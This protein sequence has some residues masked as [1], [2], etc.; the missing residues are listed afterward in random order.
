MYSMGFANLGYSP[1]KRVYRP[2]A[3]GNTSR[4]G[5]TM[6]TSSAGNTR[7]DYTR[8]G[9]RKLTG[10]MKDGVNSASRYYLRFRDAYRQAAIDLTLGQPVP[11][12]IFV[13][14]SEVDEI[15]GSEISEKEENLKMIIEDCKK[16]LIVEPELCLG[17]WAL[18]NADPVEGDSDQQDMDIILLLSQRSVYV[19]WYDD[20]IEQ[21]TRYQRIYLEDIDKIEIGMEPAVFKSKHPCLRLTYH[22][23]DGEGLI[24]MFRLPANRFFNNKSTA[25]QTNEDARDSLKV[26]AET[27]KSAQLIMSMEL[28]V[29][30]KLKL[31]KKK[32]TTH[33]DIVD[34][35]KQQH[36]NSLA[37]IS[38][39]RDISADM[40]SSITEDTGMTTLHPETT[41]GKPEATTARSK[42]PLDFLNS[43]PKPNLTSA[44]ARFSFPKPNL[45]VNLQNLN[46]MKRIKRIR[47]G[48]DKDDEDEVDIMEETSKD[49]VLD[50]CGILASSPNQIILSSMH[51]KAENKRNSAHLEH[52]HSRHE[53]GL[54]SEDAAPQRR[55]FN[56]DDMESN[57]FVRLD[58][59]NNTSTLKDTEQQ[60][61]IDGHSKPNITKHTNT[62]W[63]SHERQQ[64]DREGVLIYSDNKDDEEDYTVMRSEEVQ[65]IL[66][67]CHQL[68]H[69]HMKT[70]LS[71]TTLSM[72][73]LPVTDDSAAGIASKID[74]R[75]SGI[76]SRFKMKMSNLSKPMSRMS[77]TFIP[78]TNIRKSQRAIEVFEQLMK[79]QNPGE[80]KTCF[81]FI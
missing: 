75:D 41:A 60:D 28:E 77:E 21:V 51:L 50:S 8:T 61:E 63:S 30:E 35:L 32:A 79:E 47:D 74:N 6:V 54:N 40:N 2:V 25:V 15:D 78:G 38:L 68:H 58:L 27:F 20:E 70:S 45:K 46:L 43:L 69:P 1:Q 49:V 62:I 7:G 12:S 5:P 3:E 16:M 66:D 56:F 36:E 22:H 42:S 13:P 80:C 26:I 59:V 10:L 53:S 64:L 31:E 29:V 81:M 52:P 17:G 57:T 76:V 11:E 73:I 4:S 23:Q 14:S 34:I 33:P 19:A 72:S 67:K 37:S 65:A 39:P 24:H 71:D 18:V 9:E 55:A 44:T 48:D